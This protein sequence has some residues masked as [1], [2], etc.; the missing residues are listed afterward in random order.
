MVL[1]ETIVKILLGK[2]RMVLQNFVFFIIP[3]FEVGT[4]KNLIVFYMLK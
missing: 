4:I 1:N 2:V 3:Q